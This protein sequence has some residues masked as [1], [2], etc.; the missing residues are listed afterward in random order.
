MVIHVCLAFDCCSLWSEQAQG[1]GHRD[2]PDCR[3]N[4][5]GWFTQSLHLGVHVE[6]H[7][8]LVRVHVP[9]VAGD[10]VQSPRLCARFILQ[11]LQSLVICFSMASKTS[12]S[13]Y[14]S[15]IAMA[16]LLCLS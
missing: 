14:Q 3:R 8:D 16:A 15:N 5:L 10:V 13:P 7:L 1:I 4:L 11:V 2:D 12:P 6:N 9:A